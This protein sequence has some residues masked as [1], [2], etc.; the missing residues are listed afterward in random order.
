MTTTTKNQNRALAGTGYPAPA[1]LA[2]P[3]DLQPNEQR[4]IVEAVNPLIAD[5]FALYVKTKNYHWHVSGQHFRD[6]HLLFDEQAA[7]LLASIDLLA[8]RVRRIG[9][10]TLRSIGHIQKLTH[11]QDDQEDE[12]ATRDMVRRL[13]DDNHNMARALRQTIAICEDNRDSV[14]ANVMQ[15]LLDQTEKRVWFLFEIS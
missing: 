4:S 6:Y 1:S 7:Q 13:L 14:T 5:T 2:T 3:T 10:T 12:V 11:V 8:E 15:E 9:G